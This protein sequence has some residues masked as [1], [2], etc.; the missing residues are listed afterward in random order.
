MY[1]RI[2]ATHTHTHTDETDFQNDV[3]G[4]TGGKYIGEEPTEPQRADTSLRVF[5]W[6]SLALGPG[7][8]VQTKEKP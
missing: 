1:N 4:S 3:I 2:F 5:I 7:W 8:F 6:N